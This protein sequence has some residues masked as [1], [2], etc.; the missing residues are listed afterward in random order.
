M[1]HREFID[2][3]SRTWQVWEVIPTQAQRSGDP[4][5]ERREAF[6]QSAAITGRAALVGPMAS[7]WLCFETAGEKR[8]LAPYPDDW[9]R[10]TD[11]QLEQLCGQGESARARHGRLVE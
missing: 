8:R 4:V 5:S 2:S 6:E 1:A 7:G 9:S 11:Q 10:M 3:A